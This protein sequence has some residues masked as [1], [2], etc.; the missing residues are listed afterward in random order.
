MTFFILEQASINSEIKNKLLKNIDDPA[1]SNPMMTA[2]FERINR[3]IN[4]APH[5]KKE[6]LVN[7][8]IYVASIDSGCFSSHP[9]LQGMVVHDEAVVEGDDATIDE[10]NHGT[11][12]AGIVWRYAGQIINGFKGNRSIVKMINIKLGNAGCAEGFRK[13][14]EIIENWE[15]AN[16]GKK[17]DIITTSCGL[18]KEE[19]K[20]QRQ[21]I[22]DLNNKLQTLGTRRIIMSAAANEGKTKPQTV[23][24]PATQQPVLGITAL[25]DFGNVTKFASQ[26]DGVDFAFPGENVASISRPKKEDEDD[27]DFVEIPGLTDNW[28]KINNSG[29]S[30]SSPHCAAAIANLWAY[31]HIVIGKEARAATTE[32][33][34]IK[35]LMI[36]ISADE[37]KHQTGYG[38]PGFTKL[39]KANIVNKMVDYGLFKRDDP[40]INQ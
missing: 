21:A 2:N 39:T 26:G 6:E 9:L 11:I 18:M 37:R 7:D 30:F 12:V 22:I 29:T 13:A 23:M 33:D 17:V 28:W 16:P 38:F 31:I 4:E 8:P 5:D 10:A 24:W 35:D 3:E 1:L 34:F 25:D 32:T 19:L 14:F 36:D 20:G 27:D 40:A 15:S